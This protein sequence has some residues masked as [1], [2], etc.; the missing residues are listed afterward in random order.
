MNKLDGGWQQDAIMDLTK[1]SAQNSLGSDL[2]TKKDMY[3]AIV[4]YANNKDVF[5]SF[6]TITKN[7][8]GRE[9]LMGSDYDLYTSHAYSIKGYNPDTGMVYIS[10]PHKADIITEIPIY[11]LMRYIR[12]VTVAKLR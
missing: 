10:N 7:T 5:V 12:H 4:N 11:E 2:T 9:K 1:I 3:E 8:F 6:G